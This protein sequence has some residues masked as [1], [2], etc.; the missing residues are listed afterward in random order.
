MSELALCCRDLIVS[1]PA[2]GADLG[3]ILIGHQLEGVLEEYGLA[4]VP[5]VPNSVMRAAC[6]GWFRSFSDRYRAM[7]LAVWST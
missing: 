6:R 4:I 3:T 1:P 2:G 7:L 5:Q